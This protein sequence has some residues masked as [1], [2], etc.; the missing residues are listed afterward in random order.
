MPLY[1]GA[2]LAS[3]LNRYGQMP[4]RS[5]TLL[6][7]QIC[8]AL[9]FLWQRR[10]AVHGDVK[11]ANIWITHS[12]AALLMDFNVYGVLVRSAPLRVGTSGYTAPEALRGQVTPTSDVFSLG[13][14]LYECLAGVASLADDQAVL[15]GRMAR[16]RQLRHDA[17]PELVDVVERALSHLPEQR[18]Q[19]ARKFRTALRYR[20]RAHLSFGLDV[21]AVSIPAVRRLRGASAEL[22]APR[23]S[24][25]G[26]PAHCIA[27][28]S[29]AVRAE[30]KIAKRDV[31]AAGRRQSGRSSL[32]TASQF[33][34]EAIEPSVMALVSK[35]PETGEVS[36]S[37][38][39]PEWLL[40][41]VAFLILVSTYVEQGG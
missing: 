3:A 19:S 30:V 7:D 28:R 10:Q 17:R 22:R 27:G 4:F 14:V 23:G 16:L 9:D 1:P 29:S 38:L 11:P 34:A 39:A 13:C 32:A 26:R 2:D 37:D 24:A 20:G 15:T 41:R 31:L 33:R 5:A 36:A 25:R 21:A 8:S 6:V 40:R 12:G 35:S 18:Y